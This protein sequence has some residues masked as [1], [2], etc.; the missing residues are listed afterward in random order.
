MTA[1]PFYD[2]LPAEEPELPVQETAEPGAQLE[3]V[4]IVI[5]RECEFK[6]K[7]CGAMIG[8]DGEKV[9]CEKPKSNRVHSKAE[10]EAGTGHDFKRRNGCARCGKAKN[11]PA[12]LGAPESFNVFASGSWEAY[13]TAKA[14]W[15]KVLKPKLRESGLPLG[16]GR[17]VVE[18]ECS[19]GDE[20]DR[21]QDNHRVVMV[22]ALGDALVENGYLPKDTWGMYDFGYLA[23]NEVEGVNRLVLTLIPFAPE[24]PAEPAQGALL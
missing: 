9:L 24:L 6:A 7:T 3:P 18:G 8:P 21:D 5:V 23:R 1:D 11:D 15:H 2:G 10:R 20:K 12:H 16:C 17:I 19:F 13:Q 14:R 4:T 22:K